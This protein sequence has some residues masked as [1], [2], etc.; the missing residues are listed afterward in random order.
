[1]P[2]SPAP[3]DVFGIDLLGNTLLVYGTDEQKRHH[4]PRILSGEDRWC[5]GYSEPEAG[6]DV[7]GVRTR[8][9][10]R[11]G[12]W[13]VNGQ[14]IWVTF[15]HEANWAFVLARTDR[16]AT[17]HRGLSLLLVPL[18]QPGV[19]V[20]P[21]RTMSGDAE[22]N[23]VFL[24]DARTAE[25]N[26][27]GGVND[28]WTVALALLEFERGALATYEA[29]VS[30]IELDRLVELARER[31]RADDPVV[32]QRLAWCHAKVEIQRYLALR[33]VTSMTSGGPPG[34]DSSINKIFGSEYHQAVT[35]LAMAIL[36]M[37]ATAPSGQAARSSL[38]PE[39][40]GAPNSSRAW[41]TSFLGARAA[42]IYGGSSQ[43]QRN[44]IGELVLGLPREPRVD[45]GRS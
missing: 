31:S 23:E 2:H 11:D 12:E 22:F 32:R 18:E 38:E 17:A 7:A 6:S 26:V 9:D 8:A 42:T 14:K 30:R 20:R 5:Q 35:E 13:V 16:A 37:D 28:G 15:A 21:I 33:A 34:G 3:T 36:A 1:M 10:L 45:R 24:T 39:P 44:I 19:E 41:V 4:L 40:L 43:I 29:I 25:E 27:V